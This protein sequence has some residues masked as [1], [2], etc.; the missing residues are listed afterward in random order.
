MP[1]KCKIKIEDDIKGRENIDQEYEKT[2]QVILAKWSLCMAQHI[3]E[4][5]QIPYT[6]IPQVVAGLAV[7]EAW[8]RKKARMHEVRQAGFQVHALARSAT[9]PIISSAYRVTGQAIGSGHMR[10]HAMVASDYAIKVINLLYPHHLEEA[11]KE[12]T[13]QWNM[14][15]KIKSEESNTDIS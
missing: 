2:D 1:T 10:E 15:L 7:N 3:L 14:L 8:Q 13:W 5:V 4:L 6:T 11:T 12:R 9:D